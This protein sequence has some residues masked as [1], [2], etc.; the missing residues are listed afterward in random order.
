[1]A[2]TRVCLNPEQAVLNCCDSLVRGEIVAT[3]SQCNSFFVGICA[4]DSGHNLSTSS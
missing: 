1:M 4:S 3:V 2:V